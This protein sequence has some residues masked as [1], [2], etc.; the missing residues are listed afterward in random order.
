MHAKVRWNA[1]GR[2]MLFSCLCE[3]T[4]VLSADGTRASEPAKNPFTGARAMAA[5]QNVT[6]RTTMA[7]GFA[8]HYDVG[9]S[10]IRH[11]QDIFHNKL[12]VSP[13][14]TQCHNYLLQYLILCH[15]RWF[16]YTL[17]G[18]QVD[19]GTST[20]ISAPRP[21]ASRPRPSVRLGIFGLI[22]SLPFDAHCCHMGTVVQHP[23]P[24]RVKP[25]FVIFD[26]RALWRAVLSIREPGCQKLQIAV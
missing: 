20:P 6:S 12:K 25:S 5:R 17:S 18:L 14:L 26:I 1:C 3:F 13:T 10:K 16:S 4:T 8:A 2:P 9:K 22:D 23:V 11:I 15:S 21:F 7:P 19:D 24:D